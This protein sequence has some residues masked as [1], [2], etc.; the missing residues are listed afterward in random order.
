MNNKTHV[1]LVHI[2]RRA[3]L[4]WYKAWAIRAAAIV[5]AGIKGL[6]LRETAGLAL[7]AGAVTCGSDSPN[8]EELQEILKL[9]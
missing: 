4:P 2:S 5:L 3:A 6:G 1:P 7:R 8:A 9:L